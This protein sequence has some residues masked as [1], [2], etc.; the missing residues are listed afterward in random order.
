MNKYLKFTIFTVFTL[1]SMFFTLAGTL[2]IGSRLSPSSSY[3]MQYVYG[4]LF[5]FVPMVGLMLI[6]TYLFKG[7]VFM[8]RYVN[9]QLRIVI[10]LLTK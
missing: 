4:S 8:Q 1:V 3:S 9:F 2:I 5:V 6:D 10:W 7:K